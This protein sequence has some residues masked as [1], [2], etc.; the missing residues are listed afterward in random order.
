MGNLASTYRNQGR[1][2]E[3]EKLEVQ[4]METS[5][6][7]LGAD[8]PDTLTSMNNL[9][10]TWKGQGRHTDALALMEDC[11]QTRRRVLG[12]EHP[13]TLSSLAAIAK[14]SS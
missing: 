8:H 13:H 11:A 10:F 12:E 4:V 14:W 1:W 3:A 5:K 2:L 7:K 9:A 6:T